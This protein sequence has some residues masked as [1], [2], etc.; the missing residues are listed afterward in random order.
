MTFMQ[1]PHKHIG[2]T[3]FLLL[4]FAHCS[5]AQ[6][7]P[8]KPALTD[9]IPL[10]AKQA[11]DFALQNQATVR[12]AKLDELVQLA[13]NKEVAGLALPTVTG[14]GQFQHSP[15]VQKQLIDASNFSDTLPK[16]TLVPFAFGLK[17]NVV[18]EVRVSQVLFDPSVLVALQARETLEQLASRGVQKAEID[19]KVNVYKAYYNVLSAR[20]ALGILS[21]NISNLEKLLRDTKETYKNGLVEKL[22]VDRLT[23]QLTN[24]QTEQ[25]KLQNVSEVGIAVLK[26]QM[27]M[28]IKQEITL[29]DT[30]STEGIKSDISVDHFD[31]SQR[32]E[33]Q[34]LQSQKKAYEYDLKRYKYNA[35]PTLALFGTGGASRASDVFNYFKQENWYGYVS[36]GVNLTV[37]I[38]AGFQRRRKEDQAF[39]AV[40]KAEV[41]LDDVKL[42][43]DLEQS[44]STTSLRNNLLTLDA[45]ESNMKLA[46]EVYNMTQTKYKEGVGSSLEMSNAE[47]DLYTAQNNYFNALYNAIVSKVDYMKAYG[48]L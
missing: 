39:L 3:G 34:L 18:G 33:Y 25:T 10:S 35:L 22:D 5:M 26:Y 43:I 19:V 44:Q 23:V 28:P 4:I 9:A 40:K 8:A 14:N 17:F 20:K 7:P 30:L 36:Y 11:V 29:T 2:L 48:K 21:G 38:F 12:N 37:P 27:G 15:I 6:Q 45:Q 24:L 47:N 41:N 1:S 13:K 32:I 31:Y 16:G 42:G 46:Q